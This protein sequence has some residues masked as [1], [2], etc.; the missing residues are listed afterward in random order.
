MPNEPY[1]RSNLESIL[2]YKEFFVKTI[3]AVSLLHI[4][5]IFT[6]VIPI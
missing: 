2:E 1:N 4:M 6:G 5:S 3:F